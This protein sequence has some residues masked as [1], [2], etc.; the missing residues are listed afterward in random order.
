MVFNRPS[1]NTAQNSG[2]DS[3]TTRDVLNRLDRTIRILEGELA[4]PNPFGTRS[5]LIGQLR[6][7][8]ALKVS[9]ETAVQTGALKMN[10]A[11]FNNRGKPTAKPGSFIASVLKR[12][13]ASFGLFSNQFSIN[14]GG[15]GPR[16]KFNNKA[17][18]KARN[19]AAPTYM[20]KRPPKKNNNRNNGGNNKGNNGGNNGGGFAEPKGPAGSAYPGITG[21]IFG[22]DGTTPVQMTPSR[23]VPHMWP[24][25]DAG[26]YIFDET[27]NPIPVKP[28][29]K[30]PGTV[31]TYYGQAPLELGGGANMK[32]PD[33]DYQGIL[34]QPPSSTTITTAQAA[35][36]SLYIPSAGDIVLD[37][38]KT[39]VHSADKSGT[40]LKFDIAGN[41]PWIGVGT[42]HVFTSDGSPLQKAA[43]VVVPG[44]TTKVYSEGLSLLNV[45][46]GVFVPGSGAHGAGG[47]VRTKV[48]TSTSPAEQ[49]TW[50]AGADAPWDSNAATRFN[51]K[52]A[53][54]TYAIANSY[55][56]QTNKV[57]DS[58]FSAYAIAAGK[59]VPGSSGYDRTNS[60]T[61]D[62][63]GIG[64]AALVY[65]A[66][67][68]PVPKTRGLIVPGAD[69]KGT[70]QVYTS[71]GS[72]A[73]V[74]TVNPGDALILAKGTSQE[75]VYSEGFTPLVKSSGVIVP[76]SQG[77]RVYQALEPGNPASSVARDLA[78]QS[79]I[80]EMP[81]PHWK[82]KDPSEKPPMI[83]VVQHQVAF[84]PSSAKG[85]QI[86]GRPY[87]PYAFDP[88]MG[89]EPGRAQPTRIDQGQGPGFILFPGENHNQ[90]VEQGAEGYSTQK[91]NLFVARDIGAL[92]RGEVSP[93]RNGL[94]EVTNLAKNLQAAE[95]LSVV[96]D[97]TGD[98]GTALSIQLQGS[99][100]LMYTQGLG[101]STSTTSSSR[102]S[103]GFRNFIH[104]PRAN[105]RWF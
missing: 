26:H 88:S 46:P 45:A 37:G 34:E 4:K 65:N 8:K 40:P 59:E 52:G 83:Q 49:L 93:F 27:L 54:T 103:G 95:T 32:Y 35:S 6:E 87:V 94:F 19:K 47:S 9:L 2:V 44:Q 1:N 23:P 36:G 102:S 104:D 70:R 28:G 16:F 90:I 61:G 82:P 89:L 91:G 64:P 99:R 62:A 78:T 5:Q 55:P 85:V 81:D 69:G 58:D 17:P 43:G 96:S 39:H 12:A 79:V 30:V 20:Y 75:A 31:K 100:S 15:Q 51:D 57:F 73:S 101:A 21:Y 105:G 50:Q 24:H 97:A 76:N 10:E 53:I 86:E 13:E 42:S 92:Q 3:E 72:G 71:D 74:Q 25:T 18:N 60:E 22:K 80:V 48:Y 56:G 29:I 7:A 11:L 14:N 41:I 67:L 68:K 63:D 98:G 77:S 38:K 66:A 33:G 84:M